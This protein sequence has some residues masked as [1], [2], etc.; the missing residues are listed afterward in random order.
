MSKACECCGR[1]I[2]D[3][4]SFERHIYAENITI[5]LCENCKDQYDGIKIRTDKERLLKS[6]NWA[7]FMIQSETSTISAKNALIVESTK[8][9]DYIDSIIKCDICGSDITKNTARI[10]EY[11]K[12]NYTLCLG[13]NIKFNTLKNQNN[14]ATLIGDREWFLTQIK[15]G[16]VNPAKRDNLNTLTRDARI[17]I[18]DS[19]KKEETTQEISDT[20]WIMA[21]S[22]LLAMIMEML[23]GTLIGG[24]AGFVIGDGILGAVFGA[25]IGFWLCSTIGN[26][27]RTVSR[28]EQTLTKEISNLKKQNK[29]L[30]DNILLLC[31]ESG[32]KNNDDNQQ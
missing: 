7:N 14:S 32:N 10:N 31:N 8:A 22:P 18:L 15:N 28:T 16:T 20:N 3:E 27:S 6:I 21:I 29:E 13:C 5:E 1:N 11:K 9:T 25:L 24:L 30:S 4:R 17:H 23:G 2:T 26:I 19:E 12:C